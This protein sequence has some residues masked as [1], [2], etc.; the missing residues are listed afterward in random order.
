MTLSH[1]TNSQNA[2]PL[3]IESAEA[4]ISF[5]T[6]HHNQAPMAVH[7]VDQETIS[8]LHAELFDD[9]TPTDCITV[10]YRDPL[11]LGEVFVC[12]QV[13]AEYVSS[14]GG[15][16]EME[17][18]LYVVHGF[19]HLLGYDDIEPADAEEMRKQEQIHLEEL[20]K[21]NLCVRI[22]P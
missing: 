17:I 6:Q 13:A 2:V 16:L 7:F 10:P 8:D 5:L 4:V 22:E 3:S 1:A 20:A 12:P 9:P 14:E 18:T 15:D 11:F 21:N 19:L